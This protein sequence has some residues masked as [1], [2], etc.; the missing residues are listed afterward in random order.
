MRRHLPPR[1]GGAMRLTR[2]IGVGA[3]ALVLGGGALTD[4]AVAGEGPDPQ[5]GASSPEFDLKV[6]RRGGQYQ[7]AGIFD[8]ESCTTNSSA[9]KAVA[10]R[11]F[12]DVTVKNLGDA[13][14]RAVL[15][16]EFSSFS[17]SEAKVKH[18]LNGE[19]IEG[20]DIAN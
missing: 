9:S 8:P 3:V 11:A 6:R 12:F 13:P 15:E 7:G 19:P 17:G 20:I 18:F 14:G 16:W 10:N 5:G 4:S 2:A 1:I